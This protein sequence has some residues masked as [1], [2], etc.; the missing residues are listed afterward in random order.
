M[1]AWLVSNSGLQIVQGSRTVSFWSCFLP[2]IV[3][4]YLQTLEVSGKGQLGA[5]RASQGWRGSA[6]SQAASDCNLFRAYSS[7]LDTRVLSGHEMKFV[8]AV[9]YSNNIAFIA[10]MRES[11]RNRCPDPDPI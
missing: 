7:P 5:S 10:D 2:A 9:G 11:P 6:L 4:L 8:P 1:G 3:C